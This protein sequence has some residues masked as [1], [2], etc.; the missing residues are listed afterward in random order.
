MSDI[1][2]N[3]EH[4]ALSPSVAEV[5]IKEEEVKDAGIRREEAEERVARLIRTIAFCNKQ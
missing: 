2:F 5:W 3:S 4:R 1:K